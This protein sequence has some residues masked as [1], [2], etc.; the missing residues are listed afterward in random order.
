[1]M[2][3]TQASSQVIAPLLAGLLLTS[4]RLEGILLLDFMSYLC[5]LVTLMIVSIPQPAMT[6][7]EAAGKHTL[8][9]Q[10]TYGWTYIKNRHGLM[11]LLVYFAIINLVTGSVQIL[12]TPMILNFASPKTLGTILSLA[13]I[14]FL[15][16]SITM[17]VWGGPKNRVHGVLGYGFLLGLCCAL[18]GLKA[19]AALIA[20]AAF[21]MFF[22]LPILNGCSQAIWQSKTPVDIQGRVFAMRRFIGSSTLPLAFLIAGPLADR[23]FEPLVVRGPLSTNIGRIIGNGPGRGIALMF[24]IA[25][26]LTMLTQL[27]GYGYRPLQHVESEVPDAIPDAVLPEAQTTG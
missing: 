7:V 18:V 8:L 12:F 4:I 14:G 9:G 26:I 10:A 20:A 19:S 21:G 3:I 13:G 15:C 16:G 24:I 5:A 2:Q 23:V 27:A 22:V 25:G 17:S 1:M 6:T 11:A